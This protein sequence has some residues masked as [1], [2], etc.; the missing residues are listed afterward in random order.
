MDR[1]DEAME[2]HVM[3]GRLFKEQDNKIGQ[4]ISLC[5]QALIFREWGRHKEALR[6]HI[7]EEK[8]CR[9]TRYADGLQRC[10]GY[11]ALALYEMKQYRKASCR[12]QMN[13]RAE[14]LTN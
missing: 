11:Q 4:A 1:F 6:L 8:L 7:E 10:L 9:K 2:K 12:K 5:N 13:W 3:S 14:R